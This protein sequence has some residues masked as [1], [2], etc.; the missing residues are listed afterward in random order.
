MLLGRA[1]VH[2]LNIEPPLSLST[3]RAARE[4]GA[5]IRVSRARLLHHLI[6]GF[7]CRQYQKYSVGQSPL[8]KMSFTIHRLYGPTRWMLSAETAR[9]S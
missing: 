2:L 1:G 7:C 5:A 4:L 6:F 8:G 3:F 9:I